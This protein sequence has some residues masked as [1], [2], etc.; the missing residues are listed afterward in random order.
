MRKIKLHKFQSKIHS[1]ELIML[2]VTHGLDWQSVYDEL[3]RHNPEVVCYE[4][5][6][7]E[8]FDTEIPEHKAIDKYTSDNRLEKVG[9]D[10]DNLREVVKRPFFS[11]DELEEM[12]EEEL[13]EKIRSN[14]EQDKGLNC[15]E[16]TERVTFH[17]SDDLES[18]SDA[19]LEDIEEVNAKVAGDLPQSY[20]F[21]MKLRNQRM[22]INLNKELERHNRV[23]LVV[24][25]AHL[26]GII[27]QL[28]WTQE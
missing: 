18:T 8:G 15:E 20:M 11:E 9:V 27:R 2:G 13:E 24:G 26:P 17:E 16:Y 3:E 5:G 12:T 10:V 25:V 19:S 22:A 23:A 6:I 1:S 28:R 4:I 21:F 7:T 14:R